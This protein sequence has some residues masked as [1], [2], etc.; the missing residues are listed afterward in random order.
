MV[1]SKEF[2]QFPACVFV[3]IKG[4]GGARGAQILQHLAF[5]QLLD[6][7][8]QERKGGRA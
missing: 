4:I 3:V 2:F 6:G 1:V 8:D 5:L 7:T